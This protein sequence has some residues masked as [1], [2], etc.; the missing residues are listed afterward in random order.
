MS[1][2][3]LPS[4]HELAKIE[5]KFRLL[6]FLRDLSIKSACIPADIV[7]KH[8]MFILGELTLASENDFR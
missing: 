8:Y 2:R 3:E 7:W 1:K 6:F 4:L 5:C